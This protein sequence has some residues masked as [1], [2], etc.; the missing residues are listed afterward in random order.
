M[1]A[2]N[3]V[4]L[5]LI[6]LFLGL[7]PENNVFA[8]NFEGE[9]TFSKETSQDTSF[10]AY[11][12]KG[13]KVRIEEL[14]KKMEPVN[15]MIVDVLE[16]N[17]FAINPKRKLF[18]EI[19]T[20]SNFNAPDTVNFK[21]IK[22]E[23]YK[24]IDGYKCFQ[25]RVR[26]KKENTEVAY[27]V[28]DQ[29]FRYFAELLNLLNREEKSSTYYLQIPDSDGYFPLLSEER[30]L[31]REWRMQLKVVNIEKKT[32]ASSLFEIPAGYKQFQKY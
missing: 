2:L 19:S 15:F 32:L 23:N 14:D 18:V 25:W 16:K 12:I 7:L 4:T 20:Y 31:L 22:T 3:I 24:E 11:K 30:S 27:W 13:S 29:H 5:F 6:I 26:N 8:Q 17:V 9:I 28:S 10:Y 21:V 1:Q